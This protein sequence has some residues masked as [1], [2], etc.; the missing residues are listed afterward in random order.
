MCRWCAYVLEQKH[1]LK[2]IMHSMRPNAQHFP[3]GERGGGVGIRKMEGA[4]DIERGEGG[5]GDGRRD[6]E[7]ER[8]GGWK[9]RE[10]QR[11]RLRERD[12]ERGEGD[13]VFTF[14]RNVGR[15][16][17]FRMNSKGFLTSHLQS[18]VWRRGVGAGGSSG[19]G[20]GGG[21]EAKRARRAY[22]KCHH[23]C[24]ACHDAATEN[25]P[26]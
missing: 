24:T 12:S 9:E 14:Y 1:S 22:P 19:G 16:P 21:E 11:E 10:T 3:R 5:G 4:S 15:A 7:K 13:V 26:R 25:C 23:V 17:S 20:G 8:G 18:L 6:S 2:E